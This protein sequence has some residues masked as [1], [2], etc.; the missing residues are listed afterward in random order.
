MKIKNLQ[1]IS[2]LFLFYSIIS[3]SEKVILKSI[4]PVAPNVLER[5]I[6]EIVK[7]KPGLKKNRRN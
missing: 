7:F 6:E 5:E 4:L 3:F 2:L 1:L